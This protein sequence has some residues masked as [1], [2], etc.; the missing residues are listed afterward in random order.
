MQRAERR[1]AGEQRRLVGVQRRRQPV[2][3]GQRA[4]TTAPACPNVVGAE[5][6]PA[7]RHRRKVTLRCQTT[8]QPR[9]TR[10]VAWW[11]TSSSAVPGAP[12]RERPVGAV[13]EAAE[14]H[15]GH[16]VEAPAR[17]RAAVAAERDVEVVAQ[18]E[19]TA[20]CASAARSRSGDA[21]L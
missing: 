8:R 21:A 5:E 11:N 3:P 7:E 1:R 17:G 6:H 16:Q 9:P 20:S 12:G 19:P 10:A 13:P 4:R 15:R 2:Q 18:P 14:D